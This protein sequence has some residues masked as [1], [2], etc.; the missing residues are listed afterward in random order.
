MASR[1]DR[2]ARAD[3][4]M[5]E[6]VQEL[7]KLV[8]G[9]LLSGVPAREVFSKAGFRVRKLCQEHPQDTEIYRKAGRA[10][11]QQLI[12]EQTKKRAAE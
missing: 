1:A 11:I 2:K 10:F 12:D 5:N 9:L 8:K 7:R 6:L 4:K 3:K